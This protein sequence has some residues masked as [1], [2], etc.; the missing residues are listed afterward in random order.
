MARL[1][2]PRP[3]TP[4]KTP[5]KADSIKNVTKQVNDV[6]KKIEKAPLMILIMN[7]AGLTVHGAI[8]TMIMSILCLILFMISLRV[9]CDL[10]AV[11]V[12]HQLNIL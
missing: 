3:K 7:R 10:F 5:A 12:Y 4:P 1:M 2:I 6:I 11:S 9:S 8:F